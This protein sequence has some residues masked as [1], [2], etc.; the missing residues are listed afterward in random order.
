[1][2]T[3]EYKRKFECVCSY[4][5]Q[6]A[7]VAQTAFNLAALSRKIASAIT[8]DR[9]RFAGF[10]GICLLQISEYH[11]RVQPGISEDDGLQLPAKDLFRDSCGFV[12]I[13]T[14]NPEISI[15][16]RWVVEHEEFLSRRSSVVFD[17]LDFLLDQLGGEFAGIRNRGRTAWRLSRV[18]GARDS[19]GDI[20]DSEV[21]RLL[22]AHQ[23]ITL[24]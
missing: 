1:M 16:H 11:F 15:H 3:I 2:G 13:A 23:P 12:D 18:R 6:N 14:A 7:A 22:F 8:A 10:S 19:E 4:H 5:S 21:V 17:D 9:L 20:Q 24:I